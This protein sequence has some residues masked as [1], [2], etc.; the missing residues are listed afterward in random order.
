M[1]KVSSRRRLIAAAR[2]AACSGSFEPTC[3]KVQG[4]GCLSFDPAPN[5]LQ[6]GHS[7]LIGGISMVAHCC[8]ALRGLLWVGRAHLGD[9]AIYY[10]NA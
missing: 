10:T 7:N 1:K 8:R 5:L 6:Y 9:G 4:A 2:L 3:F